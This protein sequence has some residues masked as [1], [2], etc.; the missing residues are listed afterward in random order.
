MNLKAPI[1]SKDNFLKKQGFPDFKSIRKEDFDIKSNKQLIGFITTN[2][3]T[4][5]GTYENPFVVLDHVFD[6][7]NI[8]GVN[9]YVVFR[10]CIFNI[11]NLQK[12]K[13]L[14]FYNCKFNNFNLIVC[15]NI[16]I[17]L[18]HISMLN[19]RGL[20]RSQFIECKIDSVF[21][22]FSKANSFENCELDQQNKDNIKKNILEKTDIKSISVIIP[23][24]LLPAIPLILYLYY[25]PFTP[26][27]LPLY[28]ILLSG[29]SIILLACSVI[30]YKFYNAEKQPNKII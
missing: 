9:N 23:F 1:E 8:L 5:N 22:D 17:N 18:S 10:N 13:N 26:L 25:I 30:W 19:M 20:K 24:T 11:V 2:N 4:G 28:I 27:L 21:N 15:S 16:K 12:C 29:V 6:D 14:K 3:W 7:F